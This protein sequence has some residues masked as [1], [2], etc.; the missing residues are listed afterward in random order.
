MPKQSQ[1]RRP[2]TKGKPL[3][4]KI[5]KSSWRIV[6]RSRSGCPRPARGAGGVSGIAGIRRRGH[7]VVTKLAQR[8]RIRRYETTW[9]G[10]EFESSPELARNGKASG[11][12]AWGFCSSV[13]GKVDRRA[14]AQ[15]GEGR[16]PL[17][18]EAGDAFFEVGPG[19]RHRHQLIAL[20]P[21]GVEV[22]G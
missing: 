2:P 21:G 10:D 1:A 12:Q 18:D 22:E 13:E 3:P 5:S 20:A 16:R 9:R 8:G 19:Q 4:P 17:L 14:L 6:P 11:S 15:R 7:S